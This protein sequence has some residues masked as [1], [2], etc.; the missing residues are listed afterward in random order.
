MNTWFVFPPQEKKK[1]IK[2]LI[3]CESIK[4]LQAESI[5]ELV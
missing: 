5:M 2:K 1:K 3:I 4:S